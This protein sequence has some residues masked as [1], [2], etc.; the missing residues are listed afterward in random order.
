MK[1]IICGAGRIGTAIAKQLALEGN[2]VTVIDPDANAVKHINDN[3]DVYAIHGCPSHPKNLEQAGAVDSDIIIA[4]TKSDEINMVACQAADYLFNIHTKI[5]R[6]SRQE[7]LDPG[8]HQL[9]SYDHIPIDVIISPEIEVANSI[10]EMLYIPGALDTFFFADK[11]IRVVKV[12][13]KKDSI[14]VGKT[15]LEIKESYKN[16]E[17]MICGIL[18]DNKFTIPN[19]STVITPEQEIYFVSDIVNTNGVMELFGWLEDHINRVIIVGG[20]NIGYYI[21]EQLE[22]NRNIRSKI[23]ELYHERAEF[24]AMNLHSTMV[25]NGNALDQEI[26]KEAGIRT[27][28]MIISVS[29][30]DEVNIL[31][32][33]L[34]KKMGCTQAISLVNNASLFPLFSSLKID[35]MINPREVTVSSILQYTK[36]G[37]IIRAHSICDGLVEVIEAEISQYSYLNGKTIKDCSLSN[38]D[39]IIIAIIRGANVIIPK[40]GTRILNGDRIVLITRI[41]AIRKL[42]QLFASEYKYF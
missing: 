40:D 17:F 28:D 27:A 15:I 21:A 19:N 5:A 10:L 29:N 36:P 37:K 38:N 7:Y 2:K 33:L 41:T 42:D 1:I 4:V 22:Y 12:R 11:K 31:S 23:I 34:A 35:A 9:F 6:I 32:S 14:I 24:I 8:Y 16:L 30:D 3:F 25:I 13:P 20:G 39:I 26:L 18:Q